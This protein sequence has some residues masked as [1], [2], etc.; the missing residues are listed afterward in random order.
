M[1]ESQWL[2][3]LG[4]GMLV[5]LSA[6]ILMLFNGRVAGISGILAGALQQK[7]PWRL[8]FLL[9][10]GAGAWLALTLGWAS[11]PAL[12]TL[13]GWSVVLLAGLLV[14]IGTRL[15]NG[16]TSGHGICGMGRL[17]VRSIAAT[18]TFMAVGFITVF[19]THHIL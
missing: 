11:M 18:L 16:C 1:M 6:L 12:T 5:G 15:G 13:P 17:S 10:L 14:G 19:F 8:L 3:S 2:L 9:G 7:A 4:G